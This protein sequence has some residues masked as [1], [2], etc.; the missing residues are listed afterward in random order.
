MLFLRATSFPYLLNTSLKISLMF[1]Y[2]N[3]VLIIVCGIAL[4]ACPYKSYYAINDQQEERVKP[5]LLGTWVAGNDKGAVKEMRVTQ[6][7]DHTYHIRVLKA[8]EYLNLDH[9]EYKGY[10]ASLGNYDF[11][12]VEPANAEVREFFYFKYHITDDNQLVIEEVENNRV[13]DKY[14]PRSGKELR[15]LLTEIAGDPSYFIEK[16][17]YKKVG[18]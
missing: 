6:T 15:V 2:F 1:R 13:E 14:F 12:Y 11:F 10:T 4:T 5:Q 3:I 18:D 8:D 9:L 7:D 16:T 17:V